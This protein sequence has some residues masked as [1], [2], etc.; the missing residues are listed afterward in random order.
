[1]VL[2]DAVDGSKIAAKL[3]LIAEH[4]RV[5]RNVRMKITGPLPKTPVSRRTE[6][7]KVFEIEMPIVAIALV[8]DEVD[9]DIDPIG[10]HHCCTALKLFAGSVSSGDRAF[11]VFR[12]KIVIIKR[13]V[14]T[15]R[16][17]GGA[18]ER[19]GQPDGRE[20]RPP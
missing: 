10:L 20:S 9:I 5:L 1:M 7:I 16:R 4:A 19:R 17:A 8:F 6:R 15:G 3:K 18:F 2:R 11:L 14:T 12:P 13:V